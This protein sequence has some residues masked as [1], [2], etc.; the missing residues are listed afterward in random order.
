MKKYIF[1][2]LFVFVSLDSFAQTPAE[3]YKKRMMDSL[4]TVYIRMAALKYPTIR[5]AGISTDFV[6]Q[7]DINSEMNGKDFFEAKTKVIRTRAFLT[8][9]ISSWGKNTVSSTIVITHQHRDLNSVVNYDRQIQVP[10]LTNNLTTVS[11]SASISRTDSIFGKPV[12]LSGSVSGLTNSSFN[13]L[14]MVYTGIVSVPLFRNSVTSLSVGGIFISDPSSVAPFVPF[15]S[16]SRKFARPN[17]ELFI[18]F[19][20]RVVLRKELSP[21][22]AVSLGTELAGNL[23]FLN[24]HEATL[25]QKVVNTNLILKSGLTYEHLITKNVV[26]GISGGLFSLV[27]SRVLDNK[28]KPD[29]Y[30]IKNKTGSQPYLNISLSILPFWAGLKL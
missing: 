8:V 20:Q 15:I 4:K 16:Y 25:P 3:E 13:R 26:L 17:V 24:L 1:Y 28:A 19:P 11:L 12:L 30:F 29:D 2:I 9:P 6:S 23:F 22:S 5:Q 27:T 14:R 7:T 18:D 21:K 10:D